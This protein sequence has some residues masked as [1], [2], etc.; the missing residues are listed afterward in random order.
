MNHKIHPTPPGSVAHLWTPSTRETRQ[1]YHCEARM[2]L[3]SRDSQD[4]LGYR[5]R[6]KKKKG[7][8]SSVSSV[9]MSMSIFNLQLNQN[10]RYPQLNFPLAGHSK[11]CS[12][13]SAI[14]Y[15]ESFQ[16]ESKVILIDCDETISPLQDS[17]NICGNIWPCG[18]VDAELPGPGRGLC[19]ACRLQSTREEVQS[20]H[21]LCFRLQ[22][23]R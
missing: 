4:N 16:W 15:A 7:K 21:A 3:H 1:G 22:A 10:S 17:R 11:V 12:H 6:E 13:F 9:P 23:L 18:H 19:Q 8:Y 5:V 20:H 14:V 2:G